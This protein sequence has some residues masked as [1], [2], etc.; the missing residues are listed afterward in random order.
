LR[1][2]H[3]PSQNK[4]KIEEEN[5]LTNSNKPI[6]GKRQRGNIPPSICNTYSNNDNA[7]ATLHGKKSLVI[8]IKKIVFK[9]CF[10]F[11]KE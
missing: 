11:L 5:S 2:P 6:N 3:R 8:K 4:K 9:F 1:F 10:E 7:T